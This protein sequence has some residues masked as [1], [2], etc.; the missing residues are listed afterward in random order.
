MNSQY[1]ITPQNDDVPVD[2]S[3]EPEDAGVEHNAPEDNE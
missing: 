3:A 1:L 2:D